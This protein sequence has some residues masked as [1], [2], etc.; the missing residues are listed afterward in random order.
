[1]NHPTFTDRLPCYGWNDVY[2]WLHVTCHYLTA[3]HVRYD[4]ACHISET[5]INLQR[6]SSCRGTESW[7]GSLYNDT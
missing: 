3:V 7:P 1:M 6:H 2:F 5:E 4:V